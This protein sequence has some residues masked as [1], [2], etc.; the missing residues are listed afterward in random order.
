ML[1]RTWHKA[2]IFIACLPGHSKILIVHTRIHRFQLTPLPYASRN[3]WKPTNHA[4]RPFPAAST[5]KIEDAFRN[6][7]GAIGILSILFPAISKHYNNRPVYLL[8]PA[9]ADVAALPEPVAQLPDVGTRPVVLAVVH[10]YTDDCH[11]WSCEMML[12]CWT[13]RNA[14]CL[15]T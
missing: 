15:Q 3:C 1:W 2:A 11:C 5:R 7:V 6:A 13:F 12:S 14:V 9:L 8:R 10:P 4:Q